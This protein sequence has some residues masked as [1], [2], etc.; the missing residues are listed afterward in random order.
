MTDWL[1]GIEW[2]TLDDNAIV[3]KLIANKE[4]VG[5]AEIHRILDKLSVDINKF[6]AVYGIYS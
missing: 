4:K 6:D 5:E 3:Q 1:D 2:S